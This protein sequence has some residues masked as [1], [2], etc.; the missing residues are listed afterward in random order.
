[1]SVQNGC[2]SAWHTPDHRREA[3]LQF[4]S[5][6]GLAD[7]EF[8]VHAVFA[9]G[10]FDLYGETIGFV[11]EFLGI[12]YLHRAFDLYFLD[13]AGLDVFGDFFVELLERHLGVSQ[14]L[15]LVDS[16]R[17]TKGLLEVLANALYFHLR[18]H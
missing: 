5:A 9:F 13:G 3:R 16:Q 12:A 2:S 18:C 8:V 15:T 14:L 11:E 10:V 4:L 6:G 7:G 17:A 1:M